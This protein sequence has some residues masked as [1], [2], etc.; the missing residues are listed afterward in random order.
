MDWGAQFDA[1]CERTDLSFWSEPLNAVT[2]AAF[3]IAAYVMWRRTRGLNLPLAQGLVLLL[4]A[5]GIGSFLF[6][7]L[8][9][10]WAAT[11]DTAPI[12]LF[13]L[14]YLFAA[15]R[16]YWRMPLWAALL[17]TLAFIPYAIVLVP[18]FRDLPFFGISAVYWP[19]P[20]LIAIYAVLLRRRQPETAKGLAIGAGILIV[21]LTARSLDEPLCDI[22]P[23]GTH[24]W[25]H[26]LN[27]T[28][29]GWMIEVYRRHMVAAR[30]ALG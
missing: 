23:V 14:L 29:L 30:E 27:A 26:I 8:A 13:I 4:T 10:R 2:N 16:D 25:W 1:Y 24:I 20:L 19:V 21:S 28:M 9:T 22:I 11:A 12:G 7:T 5:I 18:V 6:H 15:N 3:L 17:G